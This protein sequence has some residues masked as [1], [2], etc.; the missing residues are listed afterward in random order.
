M[1]SHE[2]FGHLQLKL[3]AKEGPGVKLTI[4]L[5]TTKSQ[6]STSF[7]RPLTECEWRW[8]AL[9]ESYNFG[10]NLVPIGA[11]GEKLCSSKVLGLQPGAISGLLLGSPGKKSHLDVASAERCRVNPLRGGRQQPHQSLEN[12]RK[13]KGGS[14][15]QEMATS[16]SPK[17][18]PWSHSILKANSMLFWLS[19]VLSWLEDLMAFQ[20]AMPTSAVASQDWSR[21]LL[22]EYWPSKC[23]RHLSD[24]K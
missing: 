21:T 17:M 8:K 1:A 5:L 13:Y 11:R 12:L 15:R 14:R 23:L 3:W 9:K 22:R 24:H 10:L 6:E 19:W 2:P 7:R 16:P 18:R 20:V 4:W